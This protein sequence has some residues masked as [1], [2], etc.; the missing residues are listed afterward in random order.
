M[1]GRATV[2]ILV[3]EGELLSF[4]S[5][6]AAL[7]HARALQPGSRVG[8]ATG[9]E[10][11][12]RAVA[13]RLRA[14]AEPGQ[15]L[16]SDPARWAERD[17]HAFREIGALELGAGRGPVHA[18]E[19]L[20]AEPAPRTRVRLCGELALEIDGERRVPPGGQAASLLGFLLAS[21]ERAADRA[22]LIEVLW[23][24]PRASRPADGAAPDPVAPAPGARA[25][26]AR[27]PRAPPAAAARAGL[28]GHRR[29]D[30]RARGGARRRRRPSAGSTRARTRARRSACCSPAS[31]PA[32][33]TTGSTPGGWSSKSSSSRR[34]SGSR[35][36]PSVSGAPSS[37]PRSVPVASSWPARRSVRRAIAS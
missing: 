34:S 18:W 37:A 17:G 4:A 20:W 14:G 26:G 19:F 32:S 22:E 3:A 16:V 5:V 7:S 27:G 10:P 15:V 25:G 33:T 13:D 36:P 28:D 29:G 6:G 30:G 24:A 1:D 11:E 9:S 12:A 31:S 23:P 8:I 35:V 21:P 2:A